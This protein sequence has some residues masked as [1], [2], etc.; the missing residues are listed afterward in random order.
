[1]QCLL[2]ALEGA[3]PMAN[4]LYTSIINSYVSQEGSNGI[5]TNYVYYSFLV[6]YDDGSRQIIDGRKEDVSYLAAYLR[7]PQDSLMQV[8]QALLSLRTDVLSLQ[9]DMLKTQQSVQTMVDEKVNC[10]LDTLYP[11]PQ[12]EGMPE[13]DAARALKTAGF[14]PVYVRE[15]PAGTPATGRVRSFQRNAGNFRKVDLDVI[16]QIPDVTGMQ[17]DEALK[18]LRDA[19]FSVQVVKTADIDKPNNS[20]LACRRDDEGSLDV[21]LEVI[22]SIPSLANMPVETAIQLL[23][24]LKLPYRITNV[25]AKTLPGMVDN[26][27]KTD[28]HKVMLYVSKGKKQ[29]TCDDVQVMGSKLLDSSGASYSGTATYD[30]VQQILSVELTYRCQLKNKRNV[31]RVDARIKGK[32]CVPLRVYGM[33]YEIQP[34]VPG[35][36]K[37]ETTCESKTP[38]DEMEVFVDVSHGLIKKTE[39]LT[40][41]CKMDWK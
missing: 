25:Y 24:E 14:E 31:E 5:F 39:T 7:T 3:S 16:H 26:W 40:L 17:Q 38:P 36:I 4:I 18:V 21:K 23:D 15:Y 37:L 27:E 2:F 35:K 22:A 13:E 1:M 28:D 9:T 19:G 12:I 8:E 29:L 11:M 32:R 20:V 6:V 33:C 10:I 41:T 30:A 34:D